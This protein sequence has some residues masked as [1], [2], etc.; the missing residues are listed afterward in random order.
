VLGQGGA[1]GKCVGG[2]RWRLEIGDGDG[3][4]DRGLRGA[5]EGV[6]DE[7]LLKRWF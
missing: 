2:V 3:V 4:D 6:V 5:W 7:D 1:F